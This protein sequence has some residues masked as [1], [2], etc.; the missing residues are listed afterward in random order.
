M[1]QAYTLSSADSWFAMTRALEF[2]RGDSPGLV[3]QN[4]L[5]EQH[6][7][8]QYP[9]SGLLLL[10][11]MHWLGIREFTQLN[12]INAVAMVFSGIA[13]AL[14]ATRVGGK[15]EL[16]GFRVPIAPIAFILAIKFFP[17]KFA[18]TLG[19][20][21]VLLGLLFICACLAVIHDRRLLSGVLIALAATVKPQFLVS[22]LWRCGGVTGAL[23]PL[24]RW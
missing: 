22:A 16:L 6:I 21:Q 3:Y 17:A 10:D 12:A 8:F 2:V 15:G 24:S 13:F 9:P 7:K 1:V 23:W 14:L 18:Y 5:F 20:M 4:L 19:Q 11:F